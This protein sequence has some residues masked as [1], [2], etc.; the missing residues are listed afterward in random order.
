MYNLSYNIV[1]FIFIVILTC[2]FLFS[3]VFPNLSNRRYRLILLLSAASIG[4]DTLTAYTINNAQHYPIA[5]N[6]ALNIIFFLLNLSLPY[7]FYQYTVILTKIN[8]LK[9]KFINKIFVLFYVF[10]TFIIL[11]TPILHLMFYF[12]ENLIYTHGS[13]Y[14]VITGFDLIVMLISGQTV[15]KYG[16]KMPK[17]QRVVVIVYT[18]LLIAINFVQI[19][20]PSLF[21]NGLILSIATFLMFLT[22]QNPSS[23]YDSLTP[24]YS[25]ETFL[26]YLE[27]LILEKKHFQIILI[28]IAETRG[29][30]K[31]FGE[32]ICSDIIKKTGQKVINAT[33]RK[34]TFRMEDDIF[35]VITFN[36]EKRD[37]VIA[38]L[39][40]EFPLKQDYGDYSF[41]VDVYL[42]YTD[43]LYDF[44][45]INEASRFITDCIN[46]AKKHFLTLINN[47]AIDS[48]KRNKQIEDIL[49]TSLLNRDVVVYLQPIISTETGICR[50][51]EALV[52]LYDEDLGLIMPNE[53]IGMAEKDGNITKLAPLMLEKVCKYLNETELPDTLEKISI[54]LSVMDCLNPDFDKTA[55]DI[56]HKYS[57]NPN[58]IIFEIT[59]T[60]ATLAPQLKSTMINLKKEG[61]TLALDDFGS[62]YANIDSIAKLP[63]DII[64]I[65][66]QFLDLADKSRYKALLESVMVALNKLQLETVVEG[67]ERQEQADLIKSFGGTYQQGYLYSKPLSLEDFTKF[68]NN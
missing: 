28:D 50:H 27:M 3:P 23:Y 7:L 36:K 48:I 47:D 41:D 66:K 54:N 37:E 2:Y 63:V 14:V 52:R 15:I 56:L 39:K 38:N 22:I 61:A 12:D 17:I 26:E 55:L 16:Q 18:T 62:G 30:R 8:S 25:R 46:L 64:K 24:N 31:T 6:Y 1:G 60:V 49:D 19:L 59:E 11:S 4:F 32:K 5:L 44:E 42:N 65:D 9:K 43:S 35:C 20:I 45:N 13:L 33:N 53:F 10:Q 51:A 21:I 58:R 68:I 67:V 29:I 40:H 34:L 57:I